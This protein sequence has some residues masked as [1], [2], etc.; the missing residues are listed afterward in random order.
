MRE[1]DSSVQGAGSKE[2]RV[3]FQE[4]DGSSRGQVLAPVDHPS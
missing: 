2:K 3:T 1:S 4:P